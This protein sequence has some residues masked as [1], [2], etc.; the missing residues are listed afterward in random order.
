MSAWLVRHAVLVIFGA[1]F[2]MGMACGGLLAT[3]LI[4]AGL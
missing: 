2:A 3:A 1:T 4:R